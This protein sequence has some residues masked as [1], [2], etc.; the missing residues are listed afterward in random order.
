VGIVNHA[1]PNTL[2][3]SNITLGFANAGMFPFNPYKSQL[4]DFVATFVTD[5]PIEEES[6]P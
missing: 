6:L 1:I 3:Y 2:I 4:H 5:R